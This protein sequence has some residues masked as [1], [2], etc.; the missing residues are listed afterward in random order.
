L[1]VEGGSIT[2]VSKKR[3]HF[4]QTLKDEWGLTKER[5]EKEYPNWEP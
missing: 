5:R 3:D 4:P 2:E 1:K